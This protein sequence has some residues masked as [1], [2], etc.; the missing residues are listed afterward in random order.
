MY[1]KL[2]SK[3]KVKSVSL[4]PCNTFLNGSLILVM[5]D[6][7]NIL[8]LYYHIS[9]IINEIVNPDTNPPYDSALA[10]GTH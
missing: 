8:P 3:I 6:L 1:S 10:E 4:K 9:T 7:I 5:N 2:I